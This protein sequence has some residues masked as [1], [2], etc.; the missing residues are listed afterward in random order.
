MSAYHLAHPDYWKKSY[1]KHREERIAKALEYEKA[2]PEKAKEYKKKYSMTHREEVNA[3]AKERYR[4]NP[5]K[6]QS[7][8]QKDNPE[9][10]NAIQ[11][12]AY[13]KR[14]ALKALLEVSK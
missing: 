9:K 4:A 2:H 3:K 11:R 10:W 8:W 7:T 12:R 13:H 6:Y 1:L 14:K 5:K